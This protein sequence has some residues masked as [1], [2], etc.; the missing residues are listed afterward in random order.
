MPLWRPYQ[1]HNVFFLLGINLPYLDDVTQSTT[2]HETSLGEV[3]DIPWH[4]S[5]SC[6]GC[7]SRSLVSLFALSN[8]LTLCNLINLVSFSSENY[9]HCMV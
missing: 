6:S 9:L 2:V 4:L 8:S 5:A 1:Q 3:T 7:W